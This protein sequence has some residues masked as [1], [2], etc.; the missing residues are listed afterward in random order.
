MIKRIRLH[1]YLNGLLFS[2]V[3]YLLVAGILLPFFIFYLVHDWAF[4]SFISGGVIVNCLT[5]C[6]FALAS[7]KKREQSIGLLR[8]SRDK[9]L[10]KQI[11]ADHPSLSRDTLI[12][13]IAVLI[14]FWIF[15]AV[16]LDAISGRPGN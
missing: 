14:P 5:V 12:L 11:A 15:S 1:N 4:Y 10:R 8:F 9:N 3:E 6:F 16:V 13:S 2:L 7:I